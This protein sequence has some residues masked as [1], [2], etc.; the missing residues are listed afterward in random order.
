MIIDEVMKGGLVIVRKGKSIEFPKGYD[1]RK[2][3]NLERLSCYYD[4]ITAYEK[5]NVENKTR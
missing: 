2:D 1:P 5:G 4:L 3:D